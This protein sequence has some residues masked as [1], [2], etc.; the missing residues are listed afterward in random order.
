MT[1][2]EVERSRTRIARAAVAP[3]GV[4]QRRNMRGAAPVLTPGR[5]FII[6]LCDAGKLALRWATKSLADDRGRRGPAG[7]EA[8]HV[9]S[10][11][12]RS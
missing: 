4:A 1:A 7:I 8:S 10:G 3:A 9:R 2:A 12:Q 5:A 6:A 11:D